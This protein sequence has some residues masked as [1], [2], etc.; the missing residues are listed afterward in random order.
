[1]ELSLFANTSS[2][3]NFSQE[4]MHNIQYKASPKISICIHIKYLTKYIFYTCKYI[5]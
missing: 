4:K 3:F 2:K 5:L 1:M